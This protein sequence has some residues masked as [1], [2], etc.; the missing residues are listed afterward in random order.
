MGFRDHNKDTRKNPNSLLRNGSPFCALVVNTEQFPVEHHHPNQSPLERYEDAVGTTR[1]R[2]TIPHEVF[3][4]T[5]SSAGYNA[6][7]TDLAIDKTW[8]RSVNTPTSSTMA[9]ID[10]SLLARSEAQLH[11]LVKRKN[12]A[13]RQP[14][15]I[16][17]FCIIAAIVI[18][19]TSIFFYRK[20]QAR[21]RARA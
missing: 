16:L 7:S 11:Q 20:L 19:L 4:L 13:A 15:V 10:K 5:L 12:W 6:S 1:P 8:L 18:L 3:A 9:A 21:R 17:V 2:L 14:G